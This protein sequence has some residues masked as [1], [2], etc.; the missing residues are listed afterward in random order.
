MLLDIFFKKKGGVY[1]TLLCLTV[2][3]L[4]RM[5][6]FSWCKIIC[7]FQLSQMIVPICNVLLKFSSKNL[8]NYAYLKLTEYCYKKVCFTLCKSKY[9]HIHSRV[10]PIF[11]SHTSGSTQNWKMG[12]AR[13]KPWSCLSTQ[14]FGVFHGFLRNSCKY[15]L[16]SLRMTP[17][18]GMPPI[19]PDPTSGQLALNLQP[20]PIFCMPVMI[21]DTVHDR[22]NTGSFCTVLII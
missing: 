11:C 1:H 12:G 17:T 6:K 18:E 20:N 22:A 21:D 7:S 5:K 14:L 19:G 3:V 4:R 15:E 13:F 2:F 8:F 10:I 9:L 16:G